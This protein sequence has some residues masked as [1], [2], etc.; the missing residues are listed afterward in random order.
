MLVICNSGLYNVGPSDEPY[1]LVPAFLVA[2]AT[3]VLGTLW[4]IEDDFGRRFVA[5]FYDHFS[6]EGPGPTNGFITSTAG[7]LLTRFD[8][9][10]VVALSTGTESK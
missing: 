1:G 3:N 4:P 10:A 9:T 7:T 5:R 6:G 2:G 8:S